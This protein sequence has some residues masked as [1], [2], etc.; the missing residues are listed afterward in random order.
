MLV[1]QTT[2]RALLSGI[3][4]N[5]LEMVPETSP[6][7]GGLRFLR[8]TRQTGT[9]RA[10]EKWCLDG[11]IPE[12]GVCCISRGTYCDAGYYCMAVSGCCREG[13]TCSGVGGTCDPGDVMCNRGCMPS[14]G[15]CCPGG[16]YCD[17][18]YECTTTDTCRRAGSSGGGSS[19][20]GSSGG[21]TTTCGAGRKRCDSGYCIPEDGTCCNRGTGRY[22]EDGYYCLTGSGCC[23]DGRTCRPNTSLTEDP[24]TFTTPTTTSTPRALPTPDGDDD[25]ESGAPEPTA[26]FG[27]I[28]D[29]IDGTT[30]TT[31]SE[32]ASGTL[33]I[34]PAITNALPGGGN[35]NGNGGAS[36][37]I[38]SVE[39]SLAG[40]AM[41]LMAGVVGLLF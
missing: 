31:A 30:T 12:S 23:R 36:A 15:V 4:L 21:S 9:C 35:G 25:V 5:H 27:G 24:I 40:C 28:D 6:N 18:G 10:G 11:C 3:A 39:V 38:R 34:P 26:G 19:G 16:G 17:A 7:P 13:R 33:P 29:L 14:S 20:G 2:V 8:L 32:T 41:G 22:C 1:G 37:G